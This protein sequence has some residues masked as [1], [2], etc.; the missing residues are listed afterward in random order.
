MIPVSRNVVLRV[1][2][3][4]VGSAGLAATRA[5]A[6]SAHSQ[7]A[8]NG[9][10]S[11]D[12]LAPVMRPSAHTDRTPSLLDR[13]ARTDAPRHPAR[14]ARLTT[15]RS[16]RV[17][18]L[19]LL[20][21]LPLIIGVLGGPAASVGADELSDARARQTALADQLR[22]QKAD[23]AKIN[24]LQSDLGS[25]IASTRRQLSGIN[26]DLG[27]VKKSITAMVRQIG[28]VKQNYLALVAQ[29]ELLDTQLANMK[30][31]EKRMR[32]HLTERKK[33]LAERLRIAYDTDRTSMLETFLSGG[34]FTDVLAEVSYSI[35]V[36]EQD[37]AL[38]EQIVKDQATLAA[39]HQTVQETRVATDELR[40]ETERQ[41]AKLA[42]QLRELKAAQ[43][44][45]KRLEAETARALAIQKAAYAKL[46]ANKK[47]LAKAMAATAA[48][49][50]ALAKRIDNLVAQQYALGNIPSQYNGQFTWPL[51]GD[52]SGEFGCSTYPGYGPGQGCENFHNG[53]DIVAR[54]GCG[55][56]IKAAGAGRIAYIGWNYADGSDP[57]WIVVIVHSQNLQTWYAH[58]E[59]NRFPNGISVGSTVQEGQIIG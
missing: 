16:R 44:E 20:L 13:I 29:V 45:L 17:A 6:T 49:K 43:A 56:P 57:A 41:R 46:A 8:T 34:S 4:A 3:G 40:V 50:A 39:V 33:V 31:N 32:W 35:D 58:M 47:N 11:H 51:R 24:A 27:S 1:P 9:V 26:A 53:I 21:L 38:A 19:P 12:D 55:T 15:R 30:I 14:G 25:Q 54:T 36:G 28:I 42:V 59:A 48:A 10:C 5:S 52:I 22:K 23:V 7:D 37:K 18:R 2:V